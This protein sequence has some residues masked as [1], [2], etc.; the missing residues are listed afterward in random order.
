MCERECVCEKE[1]VSGR[2]SVGNNVCGRESMRDRER[3]G[4]VC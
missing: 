2:M 1:C 4:S 3:G